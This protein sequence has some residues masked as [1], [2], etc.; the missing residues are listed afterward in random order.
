[1]KTVNKNVTFLYQIEQVFLV[2]WQKRQSGWSDF[3]LVCM[4]RVRIIHKKVNVNEN[5]ASEQ[6]SSYT[7]TFIKPNLGYYISVQC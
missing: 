4:K 6:M 1:M 3:R 7:V 2:K 5:S